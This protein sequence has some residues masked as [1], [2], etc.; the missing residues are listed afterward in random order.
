MKNKNVVVT[1]LGVMAANGLGLFN[2]T[3]SLKTGTS[4]VRRYSNESLEIKAGLDAFNYKEILERMS[5]TQDKKK[6]A[7]RLGA[8]VPDSAK[9]SIITALE[10][11]QDAFPDKCPYAPEEL[12]IIIA[13]HNIEQQYHYTIQQSFIKHPN[14]IPAS[15]ALSFM[16]SN[17]IG[18]LSELNTIRGEGFTIGGAS[19]SGNSGIIQ[20]YR[21][22][23]SGTSQACLLVGAMMD[24]SSSEIQAFKHTTALVSKKD[25]WYEPQQL[26][27]P[28][29]RARKGF[30]Y[31]QGCACLLIENEQSAYTRSAKIW[32]RILGGS[33]CLD[34]NRS[35]N[36][37]STGEARAMLQALQD[38]NCSPGSV[39]YINSHGTGSLIGDVAELAA[40]KSVFGS[41]TKNLW[42]N[43]TKSMTGHCLS[44]AAVVEAAAIL[45]Q[46]KNNFIHPNL[47]LEDPIDY[48]CRFVGKTLQKEKI[49]I[50]IN[51]SFGFHGI[52]TCIVL[53]NI[54]V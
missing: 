37:N 5:L 30:V 15:Y 8:K 48:A 6:Q 2:F 10:T 18:L 31:G 22:I 14:F 21:Q 40:I 4:G 44:A 9:I 45:I 12:S 50:A 33:I 7:L 11:W 23:T 3:Q 38:A 54:S 28:F 17:Q 19:A 13:G 1:G 24:L 51:N 49:R 29:D 27:R 53:E 52:N 16:D 26:C 25:D 32:A 35:S 47:N 43:S 20:A 46:M 42:I 36:P 41:H 34:A 39:D